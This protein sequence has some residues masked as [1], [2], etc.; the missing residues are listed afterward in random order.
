M[1][2]RLGAHRATPAE[3]TVIVATFNHARYVQETIRSVLEQV[4]DVDVEILVHDDASTDGTQEILR[5]LYADHSD[6]M[7]V[8]LQAENQTQL[9]EPALA[10]LLLEVGSPYFA[11]CE[12]D[13]L[14]TDPTKLK[15]QHDFMTANPWCALSHHGV[16]VRNEGG[17]PQY[18]ADLVA[19]LSDPARTQPRVP[20]AELANGNFIMTCA[21]MLRRSALRDDALREAR[22]LEDFFVY[23]L[24]AETGDIGYLPEVMAMYRLHASNFWSGRSA[25]DRESM[26]TQTR[27]LLAAHLRGPMRVA[28]QNTLVEI[29]FA[30]A[31]RG[32]FPAVERRMKELSDVQQAYH[33][34]DRAYRELA[35]SRD[36]VRVQL[37]EA[38][39][40][41]RGLQVEVDALR[42]SLDMLQRS[43][44][45]TVTKPL[46]AA[47]ARL[48]RRRPSG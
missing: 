41:G 7:T 16:S 8:I 13:D 2:E 3:I 1:A 42:D 24:A 28:I 31:G 5:G 35:A 23:T 19:V 26:E 45:W 25:D 22:G 33:E 10:R 39:E 32:E 29:V 43:R 4:I 37:A 27:W 9:G 47:S 30:S 34:L 17:D 38:L 15:R 46:R 21:V 40:V 18:E 14:W 36:E 44:S 11:L 12:G 6:R 20:G 48:E